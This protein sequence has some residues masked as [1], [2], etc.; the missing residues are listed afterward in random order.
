MIIESDGIRLRHI[1]PLLLFRYHRI[2]DALRWFMLDNY[3]H[4]VANRYGQLRY[5]PFQELRWTLVIADH[6]RQAIEMF[7]L[8]DELEDMMGELWFRAD[9]DGNRL[10]PVRYKLVHRKRSGFGRRIASLA[11]RCGVDFDIT[12]W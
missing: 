6:R 1:M 8:M 10:E 4:V 5:S 12:P 2:F 7:E 11:Q 3:Q 9:E